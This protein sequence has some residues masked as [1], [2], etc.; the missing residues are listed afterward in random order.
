M[1]TNGSHTS[2]RFHSIAKTSLSV[3]ITALVLS[4]CGGGGGGGEPGPAFTTKAALGEALFF[5]KNLSFERTQSC[6]TC[7]DPDHGFIDSRTDENGFITAVS[8]GDGS[9]PTKIGDRN[10][11]T[12][13]YAM[14]SPLFHSGT[15][16]RLNSQQ[17]DYAGFMGGQFLDGREKNL[18]GQA[19]GPP[20]NPVEM[21]MPNK[22]S[23]VERILENPDYEA[24][25][26]G[27]YGDDIFE[28][29]ELAYAAMTESIAKFEK[30]ELFAPFDSKYDKF[31]RG[32]AT[33]SLKELG[34]KALFFTQQFTNCAT[35]HQLE[36]NSSKTETFS[37]YEFHNIGVPVNEEVRALNGAP[38]D[39]GLLLNPAVNDESEVGKFRVPT[40]RNVAVTEPY[41]HNGV[42]RD[43]E[44]VIKFYDHFLTNSEFMTNPETGNAWR[45]PEF[46]ATVALEELKDGRKMTQENIE[47]MVCFLRTLT[48]ARYEHLIQDKG[49]DCSD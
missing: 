41:M 27:I 28:N 29:I 42:F 23:V 1:T 36:P 47:E 44:T 24:S 12:A 4:G 20:L 10:A 45:E 34:G 43:L 40:L 46:A 6:S 21:S 25:F 15:R 9:N 38:L 37:S 2:A 33:L 3:A 35:C 18:M 39:Q 19:G 31:L 5:D 22:E 16:D 49:I 32:E 48:D 7:H 17:P 14:F 13:A 26:K 11:P 8:L 30:T